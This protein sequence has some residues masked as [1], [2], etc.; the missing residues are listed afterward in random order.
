MRVDAHCAPSFTYIW[1][2]NNLCRG[3]HSSTRTWHNTY[4]KAGA[5]SATNDSTRGNCRRG[6]HEIYI[7]DIVER[8]QLCGNVKRSKGTD[9]RLKL[10]KIQHILKPNTNAEANGAQMDTLGYE[11]HLCPVSLT[12]QGVFI[13]QET[14]ANQNIDMVSN[15]PAIIAARSLYSG[16]TG[17]GAYSCTFRV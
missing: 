12:V 17:S 10:T 15:G 16:G 1:V 14:H 13:G 4:R 7:N 8:R 6:N 5:D 9:V 3:E 2:A 11:V